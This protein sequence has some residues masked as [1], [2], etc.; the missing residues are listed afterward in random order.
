[1]TI[2]VRIYNKKNKLVAIRIGQRDIWKK[3]YGKLA[4]TVGHKWFV[5]VN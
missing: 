2:T 1:M 5:G 4:S 3:M